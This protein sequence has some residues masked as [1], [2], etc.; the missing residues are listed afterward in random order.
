MTKR[1]LTLILC[2]FALTLSTFAQKA[3]KKAAAGAPDKAL[4]QKIWDG[5]STLNPA[6]VS[7]F[8]A[9]GD[10]VFFD[11]TPLKYGSWDEYQKTVP[12]VLAGFKSAILTVNDDAQIHNAGHVVW[13][14]ATVKTDIT[15]KSGKRE[16]GAFRWTVI[17]QKENG[18]W[19]IVHE[20]ISEPL[21]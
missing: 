5:W 11:I 1:S 4:M 10:H 7:Q 18:Q 3:S 17:W 8:Y 21:Q 20:H 14:T 19:L 15:E 2:V 12:S 16:M 9:K 13:G 6:N